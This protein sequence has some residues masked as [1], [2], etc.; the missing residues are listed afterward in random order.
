MSQFCSEDI[1]HG[2][3]V[4]ELQQSVVCGWGG[5]SGWSRTTRRCSSSSWRGSTSPD[6]AD[7]ATNVDIG[8]SLCKQARPERFN[9]D[10][11]CFNEGIDLNFRD[12]H[13]FVLQDEGRVDAGELGDGHHVADCW[14]GVSRW[15]M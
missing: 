4:G 11:S 3:D 8:Q 12:H 1:V 5:S 9:A 14:Q 7:E 2:C 6:I 15:M 13:L 10:T